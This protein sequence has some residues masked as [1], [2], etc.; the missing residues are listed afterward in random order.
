M[1]FLALFVGDMG[2]AGRARLGAGVG[3]PFATGVSWVA[4]AGVPF[5]A[6]GVAGSTG[7]L[8]CVVEWSAIEKSK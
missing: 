3:V 5:G 7:P 6:V 8:N 1:S 4:G 2:G